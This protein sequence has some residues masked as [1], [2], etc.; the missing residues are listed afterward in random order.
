VIEFLDRILYGM[1]AEIAAEAKKIL[2]KQGLEFRLGTKVTAA[3]VEGDQCRVE[4]EGGEPI[5][6]DRVLVAVGR[7]P[8]TEHL[9]LE[10]V[11]IEKHKNGQIPVNLKFATSA[12][13]IYAIG[14]VVAGPMLAH[15]AEDEGAAC[16]ENI[17]RGFGH[18][19]YDSIAGVVYTNPEIASVGRTEQQLTEAGTPYK[20]GVFPFRANG[21][22]RTLAEVD[23]MVKVLADAK[24]DRVLG[25]HIIGPHA[26]DLINEA[27]VAVAFRASSE[28]LARC[29]H[30]HPTLGEALREAAMAAGGKPIHF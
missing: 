13:G 21:R 17:A 28:D 24:T 10:S 5:T 19:D 9:G 3:K 6:C 29:C 14:D 25:V 22:A 1:D 26:G 4:I 20:K 23:G 8:N 2:E 11:G 18:V 12:P 16:V 15:K 7:V 30:V 27:A